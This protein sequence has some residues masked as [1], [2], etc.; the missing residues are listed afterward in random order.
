MPGRSGADQ[1]RAGIVDVDLTPR[2]MCQPPAPRY[3]D[4]LAHGS[5]GIRH[6]LFQDG[7]SGRIL[8]RYRPDSREI[9]PFQHRGD[10]LARTASAGRVGKCERAAALSAAM[11]FGSVEMS[12]FGRRAFIERP[13]CASPQRPC[14]ASG[15][16]VSSP[17]PRGST[18]MSA[19]M[20]PAASLA[21]LP[22]VPPLTVTLSPVF[23]AHSAPSARSA[24]PIVPGEITTISTACA[25]EALNTSS[26]SA[27]AIRNAYSLFY[28]VKTPAMGV[29]RRK[30]GE[31]KR[32]AALKLHWKDVIQFANSA[33]C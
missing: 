21:T 5:A 23:A 17:A 29:H 14:P 15:W 32:R 20:L 2:E 33:R 16:Q 22:T 28:D 9:R 4:P 11:N 1:H 12:G 8:R 24:L 30:A 7:L 13:N 27:I 26:E 25:A 10:P 31:F 6:A 19:G 18:T 3:V